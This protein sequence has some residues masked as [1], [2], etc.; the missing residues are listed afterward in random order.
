MIRNHNKTAF[1]YKRNTIIT[2]I[3]QLLC[4]SLILSCHAI[5]ALNLLMVIES[6]KLPPKTR[7]SKDGTLLF[8]L[9]FLN[10]VCVLSFPEITA[11]VFLCHL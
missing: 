10:L 5:S 2:I 3:L 7:T 11:V 6:T 9:F 8:S 1:S 4:N